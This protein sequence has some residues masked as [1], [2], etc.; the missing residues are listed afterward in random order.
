MQKGIVVTDVTVTYRNGHTALRDASFSVPGGSIAAL[1]G[2]NGSG[3]STL[4][5]IILGLVAADSGVVGFRDAAR[6]FVATESVRR[7]ALLEGRTSLYERLSLRENCAYFSSARGSRLD[8]VYFR[9]L[10]DLLRV[11]DVNRPVRKLSTGNKQRCSIIASLCHRPQLL[12]LDE[13]TLGLDAEGTERLGETLRALAEQQ[14][15]TIVVASHDPAFMRS[16][17]QRALR[18]ADGQLE[19][20]QAW[21][22][23]QGR[24]SVEM[25]SHVSATPVCTVRSAEEVA[26]LFSQPGTELADTE[27]VVLTRQ[28]CA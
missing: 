18:L 24:W 3:K 4:L 13:P 16:V 20:Q 21:P 25:F 10:C 17:A 28:V 11:E 15:T 1:V 14:G 22:D 5:R 27:K 26:S 6:G 19:P 12:I 9:S 23:N 8:E 2:V 7:G